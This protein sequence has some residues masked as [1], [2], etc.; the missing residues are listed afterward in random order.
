VIRLSEGIFIVSLREVAQRSRISHR[1]AWLRSLTKART[2]RG[3]LSARTA[4][5]TRLQGHITLIQNEYTAALEDATGDFTEAGFNISEIVTLAINLEPINRATTDVK[6]R[7]AELDATIDGSEETTGLQTVADDVQKEVARLKSKL[8]APQKRYQAY[9]VELNAWRSRGDDIV[10]T[11]EKPD[12]IEFYKKRINDVAN[13]L[14]QRLEQLRKQRHQCVRIV[15]IELLQIRQIYQALHT[16]VQKI[17]TLSQ[18]INESLNLQ[19]DAFFALPSFADNFLEFINRGKRGNF[20]GEE[21]SS[22]LLETL[23][24]KCDFHTTDAVIG[25]LDEIMATLTV[26]EREGEK[27]TLTIESQMKK[28]KKLVDL[29]NYV[30]CLEYLEPRYTL[31]LGGKAIGQLS[32]GEKGALLLVFHLLLDREEIPIIIDQ[33]EHNLDNESVVKLLVECIREATNRRQVIIVTHNPNLAVVCDADQIVCT[34][35]DIEDKSRF[36]FTSGA[37]EDYEM[38]IK[39][40]NVLEGTYRAFD[41]RQRKYHKPDAD[42]HAKTSTPL[43]R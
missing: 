32:P 11:A 17:A 20:F 25:F 7:I 39:K 43:M 5:L 36:A 24:E 37:I 12:T 33:P 1:L 18:L 38:N 2:E 26:C 29:Y 23:I 14:P 22:R 42:A 27:T 4:L 3:S 40:V 34:T 31:K 15:H 28:S 8:A 30:F 16:P 19:F 9:L 21:A 10:G 13:V 41:N 35:L 6:S